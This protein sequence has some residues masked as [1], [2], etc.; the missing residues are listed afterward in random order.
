MATA[1]ASA[2]ESATVDSDQIDPDTLMLEILLLQGEMEDKQLNY[3]GFKLLSVRALS[4]ESPGVDGMH[5]KRC[6]RKR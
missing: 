5:C 6:N 2:G 3:S 4:S 1:S